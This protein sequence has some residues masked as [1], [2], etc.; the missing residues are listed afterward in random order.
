MFACIQ[1]AKNLSIFCF[2]SVQ[3][4]LRQRATHPPPSDSMALRSAGDANI[5][6]FDACTLTIT[7]THWWQKSRTY[8]KRSVR[9]F[10]YKDVTIN[11]NSDLSKNRQTCL[12]EQCF[13]FLCSQSLGLH[14]G[15]SALCSAVNIIL[16]LHSIHWKLLTITKTVLCNKSFQTVV[17]NTVVTWPHYDACLI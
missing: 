17:W 1:T 6:P 13:V 8:I 5:Q 15:M 7:Y 10:L 11:C 12:N 2:V 4:S 16:A 3:Y 14:F 9:V